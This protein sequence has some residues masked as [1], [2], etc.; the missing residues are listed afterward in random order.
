MRLDRFAYRGNGRG[1]RN[2]GPEKRRSPF[3][4]HVLSNIKIVIG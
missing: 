1:N 4:L 3:G 2:G